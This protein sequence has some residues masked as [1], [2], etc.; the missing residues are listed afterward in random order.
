MPAREREQ[1][2]ETSVKWL[3][4]FTRIHSHSDRDVRRHCNAVGAACL[5]THPAAAVSCRTHTASRCTRTRPAQTGPPP[6]PHTPSPPLPACTFD[7]PQAARETSLAATLKQQNREFYCEVTEPS[8]EPLIEPLTEP[9]PGS[10]ADREF[11]CRG[12]AGPESQRKLRHHQTHSGVGGIP[13]ESSSPVLSFRDTRCRGAG[14]WR[15]FQGVWSLTRLFFP[16]T[17][18]TC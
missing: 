18:T 7:F 4:S 11:C 13:P 10:R 15:V 5:L 6:P 12:E 16:A 17:T 2:T 1:K 3:R 8:V 14:G 9:L